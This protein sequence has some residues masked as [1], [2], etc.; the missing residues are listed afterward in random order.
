MVFQDADSQIVSQTVWGDVCFGPLNLG[1]GKEETEA[2][3]RNA[4]KSTGLFHLKDHTPHKLSGGEKRRLAIAGILAMDPSIIILDEP[5]SNLD[6]QGIIDIITQ[7]QRLHNEG[8]TIICV[9][10]ELEK[11]LKHAT[12]FILM[13][14]GRIAEDSS[15]A[16]GMVLAHKYGISPAL[17]P[18]GK[19]AQEMLPDMT[20]VK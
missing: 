18:E 6:Y 19:T 20:W 7:M 9:T 3:A 14:D 10:H 8:H 15:P 13:E 2:R 5:F 17:V 4:L 11:I 16:E 12:R 1:L